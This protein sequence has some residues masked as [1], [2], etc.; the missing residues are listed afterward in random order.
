VRRRRA[1]KATSSR[2]TSRTASAPSAGPSIKKRADRSPLVIWRRGVRR[3]AL[4]T[5]WD[6]F[7]I[8]L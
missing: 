7:Q 3:S 5:G 4:S 1:A 8:H 2:K 6:R